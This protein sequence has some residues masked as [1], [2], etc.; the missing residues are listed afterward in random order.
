MEE[1]Q[2]K[3]LEDRVR[4]ELKTIVGEDHLLDSPEDLV[5]YSYDAYVREFLPEAALLPS[6]TEE[7]AR[8][9]Q[10]AAREG[11]PI[12][13]RG[14]G[15]NI[16]GGSVP[17]EGGL[18]VSFTKMNRILEI[19][20]VNR[21]AVVQP[22]VVNAH[23]QEAVGK[24][25]L[26]YPPDPA[27]LNVSTIG[28]N[29][30]E[31]AGGPRGVKY[32]VTKDYI[33]ALEVVL[34]SGKIIRTGAKTLKTVTGFDMT[35]LFCGSEGTL[36]LITEVTVRLIPLAEAKRTLQAVFEDLDEAE[37]TVANIIGSGI[38]PLAL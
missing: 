4:E 17:K 37:Q 26:F 35:S 38:F 25:G 9:V 30:A 22:G 16:S 11:I 32:G 10:V 1:H 13:A 20:R 23:L 29:V 12:T 19:N 27:S 28:G 8:T 21:Y 3:K 31:N 2:N 36:G 24:V 5:N 33:L 34:A 18:I 6:S 15:T 14:A 7:V